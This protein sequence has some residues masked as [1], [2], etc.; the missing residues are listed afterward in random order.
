M[1]LLGTKSADLPWYV[2]ILAPLVLP[3]VLLVM[4]ILAIP[5]AISI[6]YFLLFPERHRHIHDF[7]GTVH[8]QARLGRWRAVY[9][10]L[11]FFGRIG[12]A[13]TRNQRKIHTKRLT[14][15]CSERLPAQ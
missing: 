9:S 7:D 13:F 12:R 8:Q 3:G 2:S 4:L 1:R 6:P 11:T 10:R 5:A 15:R 14:R